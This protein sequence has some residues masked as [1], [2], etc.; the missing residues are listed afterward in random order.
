MNRSKA[1]FLNGGI[2]RIICA[3]PALEKYAAESG[4][5]DFIVVIEGVSDIFKGHPILDAKTYEMF[6]KNLFQT[7][8]AEREVIS[9]EP[10]RVWEYFNQKCNLSQA[11]DILINDKG[12]RD[13]PAP[14]FVLSKEELIMGKKVVTDIKDKIKKDKTIIFQP[15][16]RGIEH[17]DKSFV[18]KTG[19]SLEFK[20]I[21]SLIKRLQAENFAVILMSEFG[22]DLKDQNYSDEVAMLEN[23]S[24]RQWAAIIKNADHFLGCDSVGQHLAYAVG[25]PSTV[26]LGPTYSINTSYPNCEFF[27]ILDMGEL[28][29]EYDPI[30]ITMDERISRKNELLMSMND[31]IEEFTIGTILGKN[32]NE[33]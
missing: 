25:T 20:N 21:K 33:K 30:R 28:D 31:E 15:F 22:I 6:H 19:R 10:Y 18:D 8:I 14:T 32:K 17:L 9:L 23:V 7:K 3:I 5:K 12:I 27:N 4:D 24:L 2:G 16:G 1:F 26:V 11:F 29:R 13:L